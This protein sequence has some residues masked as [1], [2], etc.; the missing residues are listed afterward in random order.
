MCHGSCK[1]IHY[2]AQV[3]HCSQIVSSK[4]NLGK[5]TNTLVPCW[6]P[7]PLPPRNQCTGWF[8]PA[9]QEWWRDYSKRDSKVP[10]KR[11]W[12]LYNNVMLE[13]IQL[14][15]GNQ[16]ITAKRDSPHRRGAPRICEPAS[17]KRIT[18]STCLRG[19]EIGTDPIALAWYIK[20]T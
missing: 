14:Q 12:A 8:T 13:R 5:P 2:N 10:L 16:S 20:L 7:K 11:C 15:K 18:K 3:V 1:R 19:L 9:L 6:M 17:S 4:N